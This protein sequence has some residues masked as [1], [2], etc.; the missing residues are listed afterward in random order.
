MTVTDD[1][2]AGLVLS[3]TQLTIDEDGAG[4]FTVK[5]ASQ[6]TGTVTVAVSS[7]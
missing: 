4:T 3:R 6:P 2:S 5:L 7:G 1:E